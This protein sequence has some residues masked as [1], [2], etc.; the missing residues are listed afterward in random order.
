MKTF[1]DKMDE[2]K[3]ESYEDCV[4]YIKDIDKCKMCDAHSINFE[5]HCKEKMDDFC[6]WITRFIKAA[7][8]DDNDDKNEG[9]DISKSCTSLESI[10]DMLG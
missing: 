8:K 1:Q 4:W 10:V 3:V 5:C 7:P 9:Y 6:E 2:V